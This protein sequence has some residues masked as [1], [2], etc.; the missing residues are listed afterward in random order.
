MTID[1]LI[2]AVV[3]ISL[4]AIACYSEQSINQMS[5]CTRFSIRLGFHLIAGG[6]IAGVIWIVAGAIP[7]WPSALVAPGLAILLSAQR[8][9]PKSCAALGLPARKR[10]LRRSSDHTLP[11]IP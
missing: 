1:L 5:A 6:A 4:I 8:R 10:Q 7:H 11:G 3:S 9:C 2:Q